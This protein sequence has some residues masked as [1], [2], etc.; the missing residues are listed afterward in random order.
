MHAV[1]SLLSQSRKFWWH[2][3]FDAAS[4]RHNDVLLLPAIRR[5]S[6]NDCGRWWVGCYIGTARRGL[7]GAICYESFIIITA[8]VFPNC[9][10]GNKHHDD[11]I[12]TDG[13]KQYP[14][15]WRWTRSRKSATVTS[16]TTTLG[17]SKKTRSDLV[18]RPN[19]SIRFVAVRFDIA[20][21]KHIL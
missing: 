13:H 12:N 5:V 6:S 1:I 3:F 7:G 8:T 4:R 20:L 17:D 10:Y 15:H 16:A 9:C 2:L 18:L 11:V 21:N 19:I 14:A